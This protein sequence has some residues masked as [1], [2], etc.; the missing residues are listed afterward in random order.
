VTGPLQLTLLG[1]P[2]RIAAPWALWLALLA[3]ALTALGLWS[4]A[5]RRRALTQA[6]GPLAARLAP[7]A[8]P[9]RPAL[10]AGAQGLG[11]L[12][13]ALALSRPQ[14]GTRAE[15]TKRYGID[16]VVALDVSR[17]M[18][19]RDLRPD[20]LGRARLEVSAL[21][22]RLRGDRVA[23]VIFAA[24]ALVLCPLT[25]DYAA[26]RLLLRGAGPEA[27]PRQGTSLAAALDKAG[28]VLGAVERGGRSRAVVLLSDGEDQE[29][30]LTEAASRLAADGVRVFTV[31]LGT[32]EGEPVPALDGS[33][34]PAGFRRLPDG[35]P[36]MTRLEEEPL[37]AVAG[38]T[39]GRHFLAGDEVGL[40][41]LAAELDRMEKSEIEGRL[42]VAWEER[43][44]LLGFPGFLLLLGG[45]LLRQ[46]PVRLPPGEA[47]P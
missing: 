41:E 21:L 30:G 28:E 33:G 15:L 13:L 43:Y 39:G 35:T 37:R 6:F 9:V 25:T 23:V 42:A 11:L 26:A 4:V 31:G 44:A 47:P 16:L 17:S 14:C 18:L 5:R 24:D 22:E 1:E 7:G 38:R 20:R 45:A 36:A 32:A 3:A 12:L 29:E 40:P 34:R 10:R 19:A 46:R 2:L 8:G 27:L